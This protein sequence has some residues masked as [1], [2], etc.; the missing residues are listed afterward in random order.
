MSDMKPNGNAIKLG[1]RDCRLLFTINV[2]DSFQDKFDVSIS[3]IDTKLKDFKARFKVLRFL[4]AEM[5]NEYILYSQDMNPDSEDAKQTPVT[6]RW[7]GTML[8]AQNLGGLQSAILTAMAGD[9]PQGD[10]DDPNPESG[11]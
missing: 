5:I 9:M 11:Q 10:D 3:E 7:V 4:L 8:N 6:E 1:N 2:M